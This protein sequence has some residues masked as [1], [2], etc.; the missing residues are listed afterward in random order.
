MMVHLNLTLNT[1]SD[2]VKDNRT[3][4]T[5][6]LDSLSILSLLFR[7]LFVRLADHLFRE[8]FLVRH[9]SESVKTKSSS[10]I[11]IEI[12]SKKISP[13]LTVRSINLSSNDS[14]DLFIFFDSFEDFNSFLWINVKAKSTSFLYS[15]KL[16]TLC[17]VLSCNWFSLFVILF[18]SNSPE[19]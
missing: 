13:F 9:S 5:R 14:C 15:L 10:I 1:I 4:I 16:T 12:Q 19:I 18:Q 7:T 11:F 6:H 17:L 3:L 8:W 2:N